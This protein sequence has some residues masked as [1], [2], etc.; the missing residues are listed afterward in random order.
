MI[1]LL[2]GFP[3]NVVAIACHGDVSRQDYDDVLIPAVEKA[4]QSNNKVRM[5]YEVAPD[6]AGYDAGAA[7]EDFKTGMEHFSKWDRIAVV[8]DVEWIAASVK[9]FSV[10]MPSTIR[11]YPLAD[12]AQARLWITQAA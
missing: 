2:K 1:E 5:L 7:W 11:V 8:T 12:A 10:F 9:V 6:F 4:L 3:S